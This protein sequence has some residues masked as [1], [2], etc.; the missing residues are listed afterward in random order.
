MALM[1]ELNGIKAIWLR[2]FIRFKRQRS[3]ILTSIIQPLLWLFLFGAGF[4][5]IA[6]VGNGVSYQSYLFPGIIGI[7]VLFTSIFFGVSIIW[8][9]QFGFLKEILVAPLSR[10]SIFFGK[11]LGGTTTSMIQGTLILLMGFVLNLDLTPAHIIAILPVMFLLS[12]TIVSI[13]LIIGSLMDSFE[14][15]NLIMTFINMPMFFLSGALFPVKD[16][17]AFLKP[18]SIMNPMTYAV[19]AFRGIVL[20]LNT[21]DLLLDVGILLCFCILFLGIGAYIFSRRK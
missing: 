7:T 4:S 17:P 11:A 12:L 5:S 16:L 9:R 19:D 18:V 10:I 6:N 1:H 14:G 3:R 20:G 2:E 13:G 21:N 15:F 8:D